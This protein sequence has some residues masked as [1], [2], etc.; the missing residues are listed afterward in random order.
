[1][2]VS[3]PEPSREGKFILEMNSEEWLKAMNYIIAAKDEA[4][5]ATCKKAKYGAVIVSHGRIIGKG[6][7]SPPGNLDIMRRCGMDKKGLH[8]RITDKTCC[9]HAE[10]RAKDD[11]TKTNPNGVRNSFMYLARV[12]E[13]GSMMMCS[14]PYCTLC[15]KML[16]DAGIAGIV[17]MQKEG[18][19]SYGA[20]TF[21]NE[22]YKYS[23]D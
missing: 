23:G 1:M 9:I 14:K 4:V 8:A 18:I 6:F 11:A 19:T 20:F 12:D 15:S 2:R 7:N 17:F 13:K 22:S 16:V 10:Q 3:H 5:K 21:N